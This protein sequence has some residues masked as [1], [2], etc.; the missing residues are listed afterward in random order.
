[1]TEE[2]LL[3][4]V[5]FDTEMKKFI[6]ICKAILLRRYFRVAYCHL[7]GY[8]LCIFPCKFGVTCNQYLCPRY[9][10][11]EDINTG[12]IRTNLNNATTSEESYHLT[13]L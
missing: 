13:E 8:K 10:I 5:N 2:E 4:V 12:A 3:I 11:L 9:P 6:K 1:M 7:V